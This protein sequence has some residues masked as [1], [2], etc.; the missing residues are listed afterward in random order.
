MGAEAHFNLHSMSPTCGVIEM[1]AGLC[2]TGTWLIRF[3]RY[4]RHARRPG[5]RSV[6]KPQV[7][8]GLGQEEPV[9]IHFRSSPTHRPHTLA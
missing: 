4:F 3:E 1:H 7:L 5:R 6:E 2:S 8:L 9:V